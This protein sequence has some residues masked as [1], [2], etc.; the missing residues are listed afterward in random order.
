MAM[1]GYLVILSYFKDEIFFSIFNQFRMMYIKKESS[2]LE[3]K[4]QSSID[5]QSIIN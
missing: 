1:N 5:H 3:K 2:S 4:P